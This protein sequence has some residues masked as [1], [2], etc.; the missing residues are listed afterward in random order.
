MKVAICLIYAEEWLDGIIIYMVRL[1]I[2]M[3]LLCLNLTGYS[4]MLAFSCYV[5][6]MPA[7][8]M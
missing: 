1:H 7:H 5:K 6:N 2:I 4:I 3:Q 8:L